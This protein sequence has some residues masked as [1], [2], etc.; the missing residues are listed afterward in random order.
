MSYYGT[1]AGA[2]TYHSARGNAA[3]A[4]AS[5]SDQDAALLRASEYIDN[6]WRQ[7]FYGYKT[8]GR[9]QV[10]EWPRD[11]VLVWNGA[12]QIELPN[13]EVPV[14]VIDATYEAA[15]REL[16][17]PGYFNPD[18]IPGKNKKSVSITGAVAVEYWSD[19]MKPVVEKIALILAPLFVAY[20]GPSSGLSG[21]VRF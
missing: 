5:E 19:D 18:I 13:D 11:D 15:L 1:N 4:S 6:N 8:G 2:G 12:L 7:L 3:W 16:N 10:R 14:E 20:G 17:S 9:A 21:Q